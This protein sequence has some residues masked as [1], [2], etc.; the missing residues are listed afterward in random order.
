MTSRRTL[1]LVAL[2][3]TAAVA[4][5]GAGA[6][7]AVTSTR[8]L[9]PPA[10]AVFVQPV[11]T[12][13][14]GTLDDRHLA[15]VAWR[16]GRYAATGSAA[17]SV[18]I[19]VSPAYAADGAVGERWADFF[20][21]LIHGS[22]LALVTVYIAPFGEVQDL[23]HGDGSTLGCY[24]ANKLVMIGDSAFG[25]EP[26]SVAAHEYG[27]HVANN[28]N[29]APWPALDWGT[30]RWATTVGICSRVAAGTAF[31]GD[32]GAEYTR[33]PSEAFAETYRV[34]N[35]RD[36]GLPLNWPIVDPSFLPDTA[37]LEAVRGD[38]LQP[39]TQPSTSTVR[40]QF[41]RRRRIWALKLSTPLD[42][43]LAVHLSNGSDDVELRAQEGAVLAKGSWTAGGAKSLSFRVCGQHSVTIRVTR[44][45][46]DRRFALA[47]TRP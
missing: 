24:Q 16:G 7:A 25:I 18:R 40:V 30:K 19:L 3:A 17:Q 11:G 10:P 41:K 45:R 8:T 27:H 33:N 39:W 5:P 21:S 9:A 36:R 12:I 29:N 37:A 47:V 15:S 6:A 32:E 28:R 42:G 22:E 34:L 4:A 46:A 26:S 35:E 23:C 43:D 14:S 31:P 38:V 13:R 1:E 20:A 2:I 44:G